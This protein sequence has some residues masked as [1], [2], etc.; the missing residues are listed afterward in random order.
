MT[1]LALLASQ[2]LTAILENLGMHA[3]PIEST[4]DGLFCLLKSAMTSERRVVVLAD[5]P[6]TQSLEDFITWHG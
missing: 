3:S 2:A 4:C 1:T 6:C 5:D